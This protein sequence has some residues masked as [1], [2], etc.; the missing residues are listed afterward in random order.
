MTIRMDRIDPR[1]GMVVAV[2]SIFLVFGFMFTVSGVKGEKLGEVPLFGLGL[3]ICLP[4]VAIIILA[5]KTHG[6]TKW[7]RL[8]RK[9]RDLYILGYCVLYGGRHVTGHGVVA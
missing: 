6:C 7:P 4:G 1:T 9:A 8:L 3:A 2:C 5:N